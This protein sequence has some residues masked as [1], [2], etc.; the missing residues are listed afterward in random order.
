M[1]ID[2]LLHH[3]IRGRFREG[4]LR[5][6]YNL[7]DAKTLGQHVGY[8]VEK[9]AAAGFADVEQSDSFAAERVQARRSGAR[10]IEGFVEW[11]Y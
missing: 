2:D 8:A 3:R 10:L 6:A 9:E 11:I 7:F 4:W 5:D 1:R